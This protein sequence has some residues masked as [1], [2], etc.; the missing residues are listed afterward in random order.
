MQVPQWEPLEIRFPSYRELVLSVYLDIGSVRL[1]VDA[2]VLL[3]TPL[4][5]QALGYLLRIKYGQL[6]LVLERLHSILSIPTTF[7]FLKTVLEITS[8]NLP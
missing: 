5:P 6:Q 7:S 4:S 1:V 8:W 2:I 3:R